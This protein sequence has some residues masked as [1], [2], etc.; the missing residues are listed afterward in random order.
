MEREKEEV[1][2][3]VKGA[4]KKMRGKAK[5]AWEERKGVRESWLA[6]SLV[7]GRTAI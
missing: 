3:Q 2:Q 5:I 4:N 6:A 7:S 1:G